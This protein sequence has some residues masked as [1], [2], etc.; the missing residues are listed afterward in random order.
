V[1][2]AYYNLLQAQSGL[3]ATQESLALFKELDRGSNQAFDR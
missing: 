2:T 1:K 3:D